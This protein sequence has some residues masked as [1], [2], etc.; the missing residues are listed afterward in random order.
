MCARTHRRFDDC[1]RVETST[2]RLISRTWEKE[3][4]DA[5]ASYGIMRF[6]KLN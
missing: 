3:E 6:R 1:T 5:A 4:F 2:S